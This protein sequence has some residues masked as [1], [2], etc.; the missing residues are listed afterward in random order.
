MSSAAPTSSSIPPIFQD[1]PDKFKIIGPNYYINIESKCLD[2][3]TL[4]LHGNNIYRYKGYPK[5]FTRNAHSS[6]THCLKNY[7]AVHYCTCARAHSN[8]WIHYPSDGSEAWIQKEFVNL[9]NPDDFQHVLNAPS[10][11]VFL[12]R[13]YA[14]LVESYILSIFGKLISTPDLD[15]QGAMPKLSHGATVLW[16]GI[17]ENSISRVSPVPKVVLCPHL[18]PISFGD[19]CI[20]WNENVMQQITNQCPCFPY[21]VMSRYEN[22]SVTAIEDHAHYMLEFLDQCL[23][24][25]TQAS[26]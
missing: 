10:S 1:N 15:I 8:F 26:Q 14:T 9:L 16:K 24:R 21:L 17:I 11:V 6:A 7:N 4:H 2:G 18:A 5:C 13:C 12:P 20:T 19:D 3:T 23:L 22:Y 25:S